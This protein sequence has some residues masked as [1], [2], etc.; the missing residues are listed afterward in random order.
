MAH[1]VRL[2]VGQGN[3]IQAVTVR[4][5]QQAIEDF[6]PDQRRQHGNVPRG[7]QQANQAQQCVEQ[8]RICPFHIEAAT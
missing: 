1:P 4:A 2:A 7:V 3:F 5:A 6:P 8:L